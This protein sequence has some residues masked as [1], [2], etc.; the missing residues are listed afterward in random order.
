MLSPAASMTGILGYRPDG[1]FLV[2]VRINA[3]EYIVTALP[4]RRVSND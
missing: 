4:E 2:R 1:R 3:L